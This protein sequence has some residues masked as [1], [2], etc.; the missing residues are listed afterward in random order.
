[1]LPS[2]WAA[3]TPLLAQAV[4]SREA[5]APEGHPDL[6]LMNCVLQDGRVPLEAQMADKYARQAQVAPT[7]AGRSQNIFIVGRA[8]P[9]RDT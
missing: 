6:A 9:G 5:A 4:P 2:A 8:V 1:M 7:A 3:A